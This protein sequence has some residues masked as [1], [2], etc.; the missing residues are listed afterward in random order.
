MKII[1]TANNLCI[2]T[3]LNEIVKYISLLVLLLFVISCGNKKESAKSKK[4]KPLM[5]LAQIHSATE[6][7]N[8]QY[9]AE[10]KDWEALK[11][12]DSFFVKYRNITPDEALSNAI[13]LKDLVKNLIDSVQPERFNT[14]AINARINILY[15]EALRLADL[16]EIAAIKAGE[17]NIQVAKTMVSFSN[18]N[19]K[20]NTV[21][22]KLNFE[23]EV[24]ITI[25]FIGL[26]TTRLDAVSKKAVFTKREKLKNKKGFF[27]EGLKKRTSKVKKVNRNR[28]FSEEKPTL[29][30][31]LKPQNSKNK[32]IKDEILLQEKDVKNR[33]KAIKK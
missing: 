18:V 28:T 8:P 5:G 6:N 26:D 3:A 1:F 7:V 15:N 25:D 32:F 4:P 31:I 9:A 16:T 14:P 33:P 2:F 23:N 17:V 29:K 30:P 21:V 24:D 11:A 22:A 19:I 10:V 12:V 20:I 27:K 13:E